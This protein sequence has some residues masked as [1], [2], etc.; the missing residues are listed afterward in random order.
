MHYY[1]GVDKMNYLDLL[2]SF[3]NTL[4]SIMGD[5]CVLSIKLQ[6]WINGKRFEK[7]LVD[8]K[9]V[10]DNDDDLLLVQ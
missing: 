6:V 9:E 5:K 7:N 2:Q 3:N 1:K 8:T 4:Y 10:I